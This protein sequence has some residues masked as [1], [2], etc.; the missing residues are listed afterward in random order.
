SPAP[1][2]S[3]S[4][5]PSLPDALPIWCQPRAPGRCA[6]HELS[7]RALPLAVPARL[8]RPVPSGFPCGDVQVTHTQRECQIA[9]SAACVTPLVQ[10]T[11]SLARSQPKL[12]GARSS[13]RFD[14]L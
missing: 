5:P 4:P 14:C 11:D 13:S 9:C 8:L 7:L 12:H 3:R 1:P 6:L 10:S 2:P